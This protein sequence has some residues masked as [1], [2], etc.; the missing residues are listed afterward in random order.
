MC[1]HAQEG[2]ITSSI[3]SKNATDGFRTH[4]SHCFNLLEHFVKL[5]NEAVTERLLS[6]AVYLQMDRS[7][8]KETSSLGV[9]DSS[10]LPQ[11]LA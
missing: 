5:H 4:I 10:S 8:E 11:S 1:L 7:E 2:Q 6:S 9:T 3:R